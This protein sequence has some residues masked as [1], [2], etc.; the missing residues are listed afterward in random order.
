VIG[1]AVR[2]GVGG[3]GWLPRPVSSAEILEATDANLVARQRL[4]NGARL[5]VV[6]GASPRPPAPPVSYTQRRMLSG[7]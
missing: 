2:A 5:S 3:G 6:W 7:T 1:L 4:R